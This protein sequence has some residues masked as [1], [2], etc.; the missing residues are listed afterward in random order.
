MG[1]K[2]EGGLAPQQVGRTH[3][4]FSRDSSLPAPPH[5][6]INGVLSGRYW[7]SLNFHLLIGTRQQIMQI[8]ST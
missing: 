3:L 6:P 2:W 4:G 7:I 8:K 5:T 1:V